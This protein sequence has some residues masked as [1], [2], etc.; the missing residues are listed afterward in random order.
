MHATAFLKSADNTATWPIVVL[1]GDVALLKQ[2]A[3]KRLEKLVLGPEDYGFG[4]VR[5]SGGNIA[6]SVVLDQLRTI[7]MWGGRQMVC[8]DDADEF[9]SDHRAALEKYLQR[10]ISRSLLVLAVRSWPK[11]TR[12]YKLVDQ[13]GLNLECTPLSGNELLRW[14]SETCRSA[15]QKQ[16]P[17]EAAELMIELAGTELGLL[18]QELAK[19]ATF[20]GERQRIE[21]DDVRALVGGWKAETTWA[22]T[23]ALCDGDLPRA[24]SALHKLLLGGEAPQRILG[25][26][27]Y[28][29]RKYAVAT[30]LARRGQPLPAALKQAGVFPRDLAASEGYLRRLGFTRAARLYEHLLDADSELKGGSRLPERI[31]LETLL[32]ELCGPTGR[33]ATA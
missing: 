30:E 3:L 27:V 14:L 26:L 11:T 6:F 7:S 25:G 4:L 21:T 12:L 23:D 16:L 19:L 10:P 17:R 31:Q 8:V 33:C 22:M 15:F 5:L 28:V 2:A 13:I 29:F 18:E 32:L 20:V 1:S 24:L 9:V